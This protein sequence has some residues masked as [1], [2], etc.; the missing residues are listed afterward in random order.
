[1]EKLS[2]N[3]IVELDIVPGPIGM[4]YYAGET[5][6]VMISSKDEIGSI[7][8]VTPG[9]ITNNKGIHILHTGGEFTS[10]LQMSLIE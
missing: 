1:M 4:K 7:M 6:R 5:L 2:P 8:P 9:C 3:E 10:Y